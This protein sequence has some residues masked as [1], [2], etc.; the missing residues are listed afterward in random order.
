M[1]ARTK[2][3]L[4]LIVTL[5]LGV[6]V[7]ALLNARLAQERME[8]IAFLRSERGFMR[9]LEDV[10]EPEDA[11]QRQLIREILRTSAQR[12]AQVRTRHHAE[13][14]SV[15]DSTRA[16]LEEVLTDEQLERL[17][18]RLQQRRFDRRRGPGRRGPPPHRGP[19]A[20]R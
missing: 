14:Q 5:L 12:M 19:P 9:F 4:L 6:V 3:L 8:R 13:M 16:Q 20:M 2:S 7:G 17:D 10:V 18:E 1:S 11:S 15:L